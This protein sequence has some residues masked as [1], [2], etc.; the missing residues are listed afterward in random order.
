M[1]RKKDGLEQNGPISLTIHKCNI[2]T[3]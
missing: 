2:M 3:S 1:N